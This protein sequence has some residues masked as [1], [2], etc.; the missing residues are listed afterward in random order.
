MA[1]VNAYEEADDDDD[2]YRSPQRIKLRESTLIKNLPY[3]KY[4]P[5]NK[6][7]ITFEGGANSGFIHV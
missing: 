1:E 5:L 2:D 3:M 6:L 4:N 7:P